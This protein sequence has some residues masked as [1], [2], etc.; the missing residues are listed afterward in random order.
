[1][2]KITY[3]KNILPCFKLLSLTQQPF[4]KTNEITLNFKELKSRQIVGFL[5]RVKSLLFNNF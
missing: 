5:M 1:M 3:F 4:R 2:L